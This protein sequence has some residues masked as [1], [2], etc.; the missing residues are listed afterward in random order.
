MGVEFDVPTG[1]KVVLSSEFKDDMLT[2]EAHGKKMQL[3]V[4][5]INDNVH[6]GILACEG[7]NRF[8]SVKLD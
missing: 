8:Y 3:N 4:K 5:N 7:I 6:L 1:E 2:I